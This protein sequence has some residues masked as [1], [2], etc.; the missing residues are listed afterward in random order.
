MTHKAKLEA[1]MV[2]LAS[3]IEQHRQD[4]LSSQPPSSGSTPCP[5]PRLGMGL[6]ITEAKREQPEIDQNNQTDVVIAGESRCQSSTTAGLEDFLHGCKL[7]H[8]FVA[9]DRWCFEEMGFDDIV[10]IVEADMVPTFMALL[11]LKPGKA[12]AVRSRLIGAYN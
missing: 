9:A 5:A 8:K 2:V 1:R 3:E 7:D 4:W 10:E 11:D 12:A 6:P